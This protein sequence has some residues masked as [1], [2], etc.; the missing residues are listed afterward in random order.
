MGEMENSSFFFDTPE[1]PA[2]AARFVPTLIHRSESGFCDLFRV[3]RDGRFR[4]LKCLKPEYRGNPLYER[5]LRKEFEIGYLLSHPHICEYYAFISLEDFGN[6][7]EMEWIDGRTLE[8]V[9]SSESPSSALADK[10]LDEICDALSYLHAKQ[11]LHR[12]LKPTNIL[13]THS[14]NNVKII[15]FGLSDSDAHSVLKIPAGTINYTAPEIISGGAVDVRCDI[16]SLGLIMYRLTKKHRFVARKCSESKPANRYGSIAEVRKALRGNDRLFSGVLFILLIAAIALVP[17]LDTIRERLG[18][19]QSA[20]PAVSDT[21]SI[22]S[23][24]EDPAPSPDTAV[25]PS[26]PPAPLRPASSAHT[27]SA[28]SPAASPSSVTPPAPSGEKAVSPEVIDELFRQA[29]EMFD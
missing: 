9:I 27:P 1:F 17:Y 29:T 8:E 26:A 21:V 12:D 6:C 25:V 19:S 4:T 20:A 2:A 24:P 15:D 3:D 28:A 23:V 18:H 16:Y 7:I 10:I 11:V 22:V 13:I 5:L 14:G